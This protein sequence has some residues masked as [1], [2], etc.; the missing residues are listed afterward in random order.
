MIA[1]PTDQLEVMFGVSYT[2]A[3]VEDLQIASDIFIDAAPPFTPEWQVSGLIRYTWDAFGGDL[4]A[5]LS[6]NY[7]SEFYHN[8]RNFTAHEFDSYAQG[9]ARLSWSDAENLWNVAVYADNITDED[10]SVIGF[11]VSG[12]YG[13]SQ[14]SYARPRSYG[15]TA[16]RNF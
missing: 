6:G 11:D 1:S 7:Q 13:S 8:A 9:K 12:F 14:E 3:E 4:T 2:D 10:N 15:V 5:Q 16:R